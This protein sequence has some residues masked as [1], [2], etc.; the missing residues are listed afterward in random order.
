[1]KIAFSVAGSDLTTTVYEKFGRTPRFLVFDSAAASF[2]LVE[3]PAIDNAQGAGL[4]A[5]ETVIRSGAAAAVSGEFGP[6]AADALRAA[7]IALHISGSVPVREALK[8]LFGIE[9]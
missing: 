8:T 5:A 3:N 1:M 4:K 6:K 9:A 2:V 7:K